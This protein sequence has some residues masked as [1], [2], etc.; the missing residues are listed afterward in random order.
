ML[1][2]FK[3]EIFDRANVGTDEQRENILTAGFTFLSDATG[4]MFGFSKNLFSILTLNYS[5]WSDCKIS[6]SQ[7]MG[8]DLNGLLLTEPSGECYINQFGIQ[9]T[10]APL[11][12]MMVRMFIIILAMPAI[13]VLLYK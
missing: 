4:T 13:Y 8:Y 6:T 10:D 3:A 7:D 12:Y 9:G 1:T 5:W 2:M 11:P